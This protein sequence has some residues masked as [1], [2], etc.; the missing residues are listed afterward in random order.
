MERKMGVYVWNFIFLF[1]ICIKFFHNFKLLL[2]LLNNHTKKQKVPQTGLFDRFYTEW[3]I[4]GSGEGGRIIKRDIESFDPASVKVPAAQ[5]ATESGAAVGQESYKEEKVSQMRK[6]IA[7]RLA[8]SKFNAPHFYLTM[9]IN[10]D[11][12][13]EARNSMN[14]IA[15]VKISFN[16]MVIKAAAASLRRHPKVNSA[17]L[18]DKISY[19]DHIHIVMEVALEEG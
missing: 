8:E 3:W 15:P 17:W 5:S 13:I 19:N 14:E 10:M 11:K 6:V 12:A 9:E 18:G 1:F 16:D 4:K 7:K 2:R